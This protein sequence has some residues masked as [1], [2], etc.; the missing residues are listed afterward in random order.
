M[1]NNRSII[2]LSAGLDSLVSLGLAKEKDNIT[3]G[4]TFDYGQKSRDSEINYSK[5]I[6]EYYGIEHRVIKLDWLKSVT[7]TSLLSKR[8]SLLPTK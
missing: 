6:C 5:K 8:S 3:L 4:L 2:L 7:E 1:E